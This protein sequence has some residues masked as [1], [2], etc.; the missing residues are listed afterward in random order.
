MT[1]WGLMISRVS[2]GFADPSGPAINH[3]AV[4]E[5]GSLNFNSSE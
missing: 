4:G 5:E 2:Q 1:A 3:P